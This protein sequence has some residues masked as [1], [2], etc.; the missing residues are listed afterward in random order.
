MPSHIC[1]TI[2]RPKNF[3]TFSYAL[4]QILTLKVLHKFTFF[5]K[6]IWLKFKNQ[7]PSRFL[8]LKTK[9]VPKTKPDKLLYLQFGHMYIFEDCAHFYY[10]NCTLSPVEQLPYVAE[11]RCS[12][13]ML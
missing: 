2:R 13:Q 7:N 10:K 12:L 5:I 1:K 4:P 9:P 11:K 3:N 8:M 6:L